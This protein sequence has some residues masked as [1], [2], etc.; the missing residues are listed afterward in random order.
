MEE[1]PTHPQRWLAALPKTTT[2]SIWMIII[3]DAL[4]DECRGAKSTE[5]AEGSAQQVCE[6]FDISGWEAGVCVYA[7]N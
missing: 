6:E 1:T 3:D 5:T 7:S 2:L 4:Q